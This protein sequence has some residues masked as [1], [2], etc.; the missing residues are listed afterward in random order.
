MY[1][2]TLTRSLKSA[3]EETERRR[4]KQQDFNKTHGITPQT[5]KKAITKSLLVE[6]EIPTPLYLQEEGA[7]SLLTGK[8]LQQHIKKL[9]KQMHAAAANLEFE[10]AARLRDMIHHLEK[11]DLG[12]ESM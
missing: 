5:V 4:I 8:A 10:E 7:A 2:D 1:A 11:Q 6:E 12:L 3:L 9:E